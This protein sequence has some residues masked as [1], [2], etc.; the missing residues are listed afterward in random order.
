MKKTWTTPEVIDLQI[1]L[2]A[3]V[4]GGVISNRNRHSYHTPAPTP[5]ATPAA[6]FDPS[7]MM[8]ADDFVED[9]NW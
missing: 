2:T 9:E 6:T 4:Y 5:V 3:G 8:N 1:S 7:T